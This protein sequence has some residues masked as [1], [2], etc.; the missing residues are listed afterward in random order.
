[1]IVELFV[2]RH[3][4]NEETLDAAD[5]FNSD[6]IVYCQIDGSDKFAIMFE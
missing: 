3:K 4:I 6:L 5:I 1:M 2:L